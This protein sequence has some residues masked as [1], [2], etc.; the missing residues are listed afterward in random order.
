MSWLIFKVLGYFCFCFLDSL[1]HG[2]LSS[3]ATNVAHGAWPDSPFLSAN[4][5]PPVGYARREETCPQS[6]AYEE[7]RHL[8]GW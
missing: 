5:C 3:S 1:A 6:F 7:W 8:A 4:S 2:F